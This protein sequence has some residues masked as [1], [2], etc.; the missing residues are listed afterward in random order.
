[1]STK[2]QPPRGER[3]YWLDNPKNVDKLYWALI[4]I[5]AALFLA[6]AFYHKHVE[7]AFEETWGFFAIFGFC[8]FVFIVLSAKQLRKLLRRDEDFYDVPEDDA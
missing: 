4:A 3:S 1:M 2:G 6:D 7:F 5:C 8:A